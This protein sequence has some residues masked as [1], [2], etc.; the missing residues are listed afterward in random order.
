MSPPDPWIRWDPDGPGN[1]EPHDIT[2]RAVGQT[3]GS[4][5]SLVGIAGSVGQSTRST[6]EVTSAMME[7]SRVTMCPVESSNPPGFSH[8]RQELMVDPQVLEELKKY[9][10]PS[11]T[12]VVATYP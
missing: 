3:C 6:R 10:T 9:D 11:I 5:G 1:L 2:R 7:G 12:N 8:Q 4:A